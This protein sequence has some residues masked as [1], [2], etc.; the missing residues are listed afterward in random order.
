MPAQIQP[1]SWLKNYSWKMSK[2]SSIGNGVVYT[3]SQKPGHEIVLF[4][5]GRIEHRLHGQKIAA[6]DS[7]NVAAYMSKIHRY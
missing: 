4:D 1:S 3:N 2:D 5:D 7:K 6:V